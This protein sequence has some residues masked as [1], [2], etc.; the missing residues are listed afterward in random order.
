MLKL[1]I[2]RES[3]LSFSQ[4]LSTN[5]S[6]E[7][8]SFTL[9]GL[10]VDLQLK[11]VIKYCEQ[12]EAEI[13]RLKD[14]NKELDQEL[15]RDEDAKTELRIINNN[16]KLQ[17]YYLKLCELSDYFT[18]TQTLSTSL[19]DSADDIHDLLVKGAS[20]VTQSIL[21]A[22]PIVSVLTGVV[23]GIE[24]TAHVAHSISKHRRA[25]NIAQWTRGL[26]VS[27]NQRLTQRFARKVTLNK[28]EEIVTPDL[29]LNLHTHR[30]LFDKVIATTKF[31][32]TK[33]DH[34]YREFKEGRSY[35]PQE[36]LA[37]ADMLKVLEAIATQKLKPATTGTEQERM[38][39]HVEA[40]LS[41]F[42]SNNMEKM[43]AFFSPIKQGYTT[44][45][46]KW[47]VTKAAVS[48][49]PVF[50]KDYKT[51]LNGALGIYLKTLITHKNYSKAEEILQYKQ[52]ILLVMPVNTFED[53][54]FHQLLNQDPINN[55]FLEKMS[56][57][58][59]K[60]FSSIINKKNL[61]YESP[62]DLAIK[63]GN[64]KILAF[65]LKNFINDI[66]SDQLN[67]IQYY[68]NKNFQAR[69]LHT[70]LPIKRLIF[71]STRLHLWNQEKEY[72]SLEN[73]LKIKLSAE[74]FFTLFEKILKQVHYLHSQ[75][76]TTHAALDL[77]HIVLTKNKVLLTPSSASYPIR[78][79]SEL[80]DL[81]TDVNSLGLILKEFCQRNPEWLT[82]KNINK[83]IS[84]L[85]NELTLPKPITLINAICHVMIYLNY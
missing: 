33:A 52:S 64:I 41:L 23:E 11:L 45:D 30:G 24:Q 7:Q 39:H 38:Q 53:T 73:L 9:S 26:G 72:K 76:Y 50:E 16:P 74:D 51:M 18:A 17:S 12:L 32:A 5:P 29:A 77:K 42:P 28:L 10:S 61:Q 60:N 25:I 1:L 36:K 35:S 75:C 57:Y 62:I 85:I 34:V 19:V 37:L 43:L 48:S 46:Q 69:T 58:A 21:H 15:D 59:K 54:V 4:S 68:A 40:M 63:Q 84:K 22:I 83:K 55:T 8:E 66:E 6:S 49:T 65:W 31:L 79:E 2:K 71:S 47:G 78:V 3:I 70:L 82:Q 56:L 81:A 13:V 67:K 27:A 44:D 80:K 20:K 14:H